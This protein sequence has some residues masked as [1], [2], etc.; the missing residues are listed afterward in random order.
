MK[1]IEH[2]DEKYAYYLYLTTLIKRDDQYVND[3]TARI[4]S[5]YSI[6][7]QSMPLLW[8]LIYLDEELSNSSTKKISVIET[9]TKRGIHSPILFVEAY[10]V[11]VAN[12]AIIS[13]LS[14]FEIE[15]LSF[16]VK[17]GKMSREIISQVTMLALRTRDFSKKLI[18]LLANMYELYNDPDIVEAICTILIR[19]NVTDT[20]YHKWYSIG[21]KLELKIT[22]LIEYFIYSSPCYLS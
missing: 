8:M 4:A 20:V 15:V 12:P 18:K 9:I 6:Y 22:K 5:Y 13:K 16:A 14:S 21:V 7:P 2:D 17:N 3:V 11:F 10:N 19:A 1:I